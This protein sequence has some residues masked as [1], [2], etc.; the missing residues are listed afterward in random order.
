MHHARC[1]WPDS[2]WFKFSGVLMEMQIADES[3][4]KPLMRLRI[5]EWLWYLNAH[6]EVD[7]LYLAKNA[8]QILVEAS[9]TE[10]HTK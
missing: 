10:Y 8:A 2:T 4:A 6:N 3:V 9:M 5:T 1:A 7:R